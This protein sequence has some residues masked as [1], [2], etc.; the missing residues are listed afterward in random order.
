MDVVFYILKVHYCKFKVLH[1]I[2]KLLNHAS[3]FCSYNCGAH[4]M[5]FSNNYNVCTVTFFPGIQVFILWLIENAVFSLDE[6]LGTSSYIHGWSR[7]Y[8]SYDSNDKKCLY[9][10]I[11]LFYYSWLRSFHSAEQTWYKNEMSLLWHNIFCITKTTSDAKLA[12]HYYPFANEVAKGYSNA[13]F[14]LSFLL[15]I[16]P[17]FRN[18]FVNTLESTFFNGFWPNLVHTKR[19]WNPINFQ[20]QRSRSLGQIF[21]R[22]DMPRFALPL[23]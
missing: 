12:F 8:I 6:K 10:I 3:C 5:I 20:G 2:N 1:T 15:S 16:R 13:T 9:R 17:S 14:H 23:F 21:R 4:H 11:F 22:G 18:I 19:I 7:R